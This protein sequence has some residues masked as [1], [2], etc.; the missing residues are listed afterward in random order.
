VFASVIEDLD[1][2]LMLFNDGDVDSDL[3]VELLDG[4]GVDSD[5]AKDVMVLAFHSVEFL[6]PHVAVF[7]KMSALVL[8]DMELLL[9]MVVLFLHV[10]KSIVVLL[11]LMVLLLEVFEVMLGLLENMLSHSVLVGVHGLEL[12]ELLALSS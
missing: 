5:L 9:D 3:S 7:F 4:S 2:S 11:E 8:P 1:L 6:L 12:L 10:E